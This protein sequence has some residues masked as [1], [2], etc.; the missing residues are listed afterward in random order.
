MDHVNKNR[1]SSVRFVMIEAMRRCRQ[2]EAASPFVKSHPEVA[3]ADEE[4]SS[5]EGAVLCRRVPR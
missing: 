5:S 4:A 1:F 3:A 2:E